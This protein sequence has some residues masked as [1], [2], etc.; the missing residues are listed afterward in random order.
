MVMMFAARHSGMR[1]IDYTKDGTKM[2]EA[3]LKVVADFGLDCVLMCSDPAREVIDIAGED[4]VKWLEDQG[5][6]IREERAALLD[7]ARLSEFR[8]PDPHAEGRMHDRIQAIEIC[9]QELRGETS[10]VGW[11]EG[12]LALAQELRGL[13]RIMTDI[14]DDHAFVRDLMDFTSEVAI[15]YASAQI[16]AG[17]DTIGMSDAAASMIGPRH[18]GNFVLPW[19]RRVLQSIRDRHPGV[20]LR[21][22]MCGNVGPLIPQMATLPVDIYELDFPTGLAAARAGLGPERVILGNVS[23]V[24][25]MLTGTPGTVEAAAQKCHEICGPHHI[26]GAGC[27]LSPSTPPENL[28]AMV[29]YAMEH[30]P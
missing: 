10:V 4:S 17:A 20:V 22:H 9:A 11:V 3:Q 21:L 5:P 7:K 14:V 25:D 23:T 24:T 28:Y 29:R 26:V 18:Y 12:P 8:M 6:A 27:E 16:E 2:A 13:T 1:Y 15:V 30:K 19:Q